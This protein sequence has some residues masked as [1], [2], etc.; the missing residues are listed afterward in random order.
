MDDV[1]GAGSAA[2]GRGEQA[3]PLKISHGRVWEQALVEY[4]E[5]SSERRAASASVGLSS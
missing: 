2:L 1:F 3:S 5:I 4:G